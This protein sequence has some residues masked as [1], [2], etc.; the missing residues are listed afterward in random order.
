MRQSTYYEFPS[1]RDSTFE[2]PITFCVNKVTVQNK[3]F[4][5]VLLLCDVYHIRFKNPAVDGGT[6]GGCEL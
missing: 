2:N 4:F 6:S 5:L 3:L 1:S